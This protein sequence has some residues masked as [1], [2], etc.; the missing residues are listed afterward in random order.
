MMQED[1][2]W[3]AIDEALEMVLI[4]EENGRIIFANALA[5]RMLEYG[6]ELCGTHISEIFPTSFRS[7]GA[8]FETELGMDLGLKELL[9]YRKNRTCFSV[10]ARVIADK[11]NSGHY[12]CMMEDISQK[13]F[14]ERAIAQVK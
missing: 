10:C 11:D 4:F 5:K 12:V 3:F 2:F 14:L 13:E 1:L 9:A 8:G 7:A 6:E